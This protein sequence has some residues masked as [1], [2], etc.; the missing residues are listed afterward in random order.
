MGPGTSDP[1]AKVSQANGVVTIYPTGKKGNEN[2]GI[3]IGRTSFHLLAGANV[4][5]KGWAKGRQYFW[6]G[7]SVGI[8]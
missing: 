5:D 1:K 3:E 4:V 8:L 7:R 2:G 6:K